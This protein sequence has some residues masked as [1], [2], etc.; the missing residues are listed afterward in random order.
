MMIW[1]ASYR[2]KGAGGGGGGRNDHRGGG[3]DMSVTNK[4]S[5]CFAWID[6]CRGTACSHR[7]Q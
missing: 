2:E 7:K 5:A 1:L 3:G 4:I 6:Q